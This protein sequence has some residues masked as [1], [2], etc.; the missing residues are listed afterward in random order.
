MKSLIRQNSFKFPEKG[1]VW[2]EELK[3]RE[4]EET[5][6]ISDSTTKRER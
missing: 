1:I 4:R 6:K 5:K 3:K 2:I